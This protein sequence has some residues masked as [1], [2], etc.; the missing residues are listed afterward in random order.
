MLFWDQTRPQEPLP[1]VIENKTNT[2]NIIDNHY[3]DRY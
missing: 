3:Y 1:I 2:E